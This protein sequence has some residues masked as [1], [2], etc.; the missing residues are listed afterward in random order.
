MGIYLGE[1]TT[2]VA[3]PPSGTVRLYPKQDKQWYS[4][5]DGG[6][7]ARLLLATDTQVTPLTMTLLNSWENYSNDWAEASYYKDLL[8]RVHIV[9]MIKNGTDAHIATL[10]VGYRPTTNYMFWGF[11]EGTPDDVALPIRVLNNGEIQLW[12]TYNAGWVHFSCSFFG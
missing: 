3:T 1:E 12:G 10:P 2:M 11:T 4:K 7:E 9:G 6:T 8:G 5:D